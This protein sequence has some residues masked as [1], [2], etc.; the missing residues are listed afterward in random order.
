MMP[1]RKSC[2][3]GMRGTLQYRLAAV[4]AARSRASSSASSSSETSIPKP[5]CLKRAG[6]RYCIVRPGSGGG[7]GGRPRPPQS[8]TRSGGDLHPD[9]VVPRKDLHREAVHHEDDE[10]MGELA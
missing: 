2:I 4:V 5:I 7:R 8:P 1:P 10:Q 3:W 6:V 9:L